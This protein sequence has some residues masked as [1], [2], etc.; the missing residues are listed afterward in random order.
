MEMLVHAIFVYL[1]SFKYSHA[2]GIARCLNFCDHDIESG[3]KEE[4]FLLVAFYLVSVI[5]FF[6]FFIRIN[7]NRQLSP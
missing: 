6:Y 2:L 1:C 3:R 4:A 7:N 5:C